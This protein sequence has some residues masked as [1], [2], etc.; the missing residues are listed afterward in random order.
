M[1]RPVW[2]SRNNDYTKNLDYYPTPP[3]ATHALCGWIRRNVYDTSGMTV[4]EPAAGGGH[5]AEVLRQY[6][7]AVI[8]SD[9]QVYG[10]PLDFVADFLGGDIQYPRAE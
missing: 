5:M 2:N 9:I 6:F 4:Y 3:Y 10:Y 1:G 8:T 7:G